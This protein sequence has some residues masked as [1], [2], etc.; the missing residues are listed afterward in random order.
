MIKVK[1]EVKKP[2]LRQ[3]ELEEGSTHKAQPR[4][5]VTKHLIQ[6]VRVFHRQLSA[7]KVNP[8]KLENIKGL[9]MAH[10]PMTQVTLIVTLVLGMVATTT[11]PPNMKTLIAAVIAS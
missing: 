11:N 1:E 7:L 5:P 4:I 3:M 10:G 8:S 9:E 6:P 2:K